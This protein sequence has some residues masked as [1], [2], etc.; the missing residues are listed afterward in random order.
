MLK[1]KEERVCGDAPRGSA[2]RMTP[3]EA[4]F[5]AA[6]FHAQGEQPREF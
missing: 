4:D 1:E 2:Q 5:I 6:L 3:Q